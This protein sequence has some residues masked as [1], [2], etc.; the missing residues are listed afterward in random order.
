M[1][2]ISVKDGLP[3]ESGR[4]AVC[5]KYKELSLKIFIADFDDIEGWYIP[6]PDTE[7]TRWSSL[8]ELPKE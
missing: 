8:P 5:Y 2:W 7:I 3:D 6:V 4:Y 1:E